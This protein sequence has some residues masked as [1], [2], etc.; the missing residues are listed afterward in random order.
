MSSCAIE[1]CSRP[2]CPV[3]RFA[4]RTVIE[5]ERALRVQW[6][7]QYLGIEEALPPL[8]YPEPKKSKKS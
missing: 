1:G 4:G 3:C 5:I 2:G 6:R 7:K 8:K